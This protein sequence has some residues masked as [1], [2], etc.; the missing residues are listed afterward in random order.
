MLS[1]LTPGLGFCLSTVRG[2][3]CSGVSSLLP[4]MG[5]FSFY[6]VLS[7]SRT[8]LPSPCFPATAFAVPHLVGSILS[9]SGKWGSGWLAT[10]RTRQQDLGNGPV[11]LDPGE[12]AFHW[13]ETAC[14]L[15]RL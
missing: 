13:W 7:M 8:L 3:S 11:T 15:F 4:K 1:V 12:D 2:A 9:D 6:L 14:P 10:G 5:M